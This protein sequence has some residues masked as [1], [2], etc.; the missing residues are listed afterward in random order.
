MVKLTPGTVWFSP[1]CV[2]TT[3]PFLGNALV[4]IW[5][6][7]QFASTGGPHYMRS[8][9]LGFHVSSIPNWPIFWNVSPHF[10]VI[11]GLFICEFIICEPDFLVP[12]YRIQRGPTV[13]QTWFNVS[14]FFVVFIL[15]SS[16]DFSWIFLSIKIKKRTIFS[17]FTCWVPHLPRT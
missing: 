16:L 4:F 7:C 17:A 14:C 11:L 3:S 5:L 13:F 2:S 15:T 6:P 12:I 10:T 9:Y 1:F 8:F